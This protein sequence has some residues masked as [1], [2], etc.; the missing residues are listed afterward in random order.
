[1]KKV[2][3]M[4][5]LMLIAPAVCLVATVQGRAAAEPALDP[6]TEKAFWQYG[7]DS[8]Q[9][10]VRLFIR[11][12]LGQVGDYRAVFVVMAPDRREYCSEKN[13]SQA[14][15]VA[16]SFPRDFGAAWMQGVYMWKCTI[17]GHTI[18]QGSF[19]YC[20]SC[21]IRLL[22]AGFPPVRSAGR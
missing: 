20:T 21:Q 5:I 14:A 15:E 9:G 17:S 13:G 7:V 1:M 19:Q 8:G 6:L 3:V 4:L 10:A 2:A 12:K 11:D 18:A 22:Q 16:A